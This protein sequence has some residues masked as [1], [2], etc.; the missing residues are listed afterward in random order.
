MGIQTYKAVGGKSMEGLRKPNDCR[1]LNCNS[2]IVGVYNIVAVYNIVGRH[3]RGREQVVT[4]KSVVR[5]SRV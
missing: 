3:G 5:S 4:C 2:S 1:I